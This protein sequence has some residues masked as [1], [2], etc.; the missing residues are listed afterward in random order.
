[1]VTS[2]IPIFATHVKANM[3]QIPYR[4]SREF[5]L[6]HPEWIFLHSGSWKKSVCGGQD[7]ICDG[8]LNCYKIPTKIWHCTLPQYQ[9]YIHDLSL[10]TTNLYRVL[11]EVRSFDKPIIWFPKIGQG[12]ARFKE[13]LPKALDILEKE[14][15]FDYNYHN[16]KVI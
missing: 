11:E 6:Q 7:A 13:F 2:L 1:M 14:K 3:I 15:N 4:L 8:I 10:F 5:I 9:S 16:I 12:C